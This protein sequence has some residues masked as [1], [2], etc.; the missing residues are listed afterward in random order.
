MRWAACLLCVAACAA[1]SVA[2]DHEGFT[3]DDGTIMLPAGKTINASIDATDCVVKITGLV[4]GSITA[5]GGVVHVVA[6]PTVNGELVVEGAT[7]VVVEGSQLNG[8]IDVENSLAVTVE[9]SQF[10]GQGQFIDDGTVTI[11]S[12]FFNDSLTIRGAQSCTQRDNQANGP[13]ALG[14]CN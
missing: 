2:T 6:A 14:S 13:V 10:N 3:C 8:G 4:N 5:T 7:E 9:D 11:T 12:S 1:P